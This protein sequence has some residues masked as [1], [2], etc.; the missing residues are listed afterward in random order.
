MTIS[1]VIEAWSSRTSSDESEDGQKFRFNVSTGY[2]V[3]HTYD[4]E[5][6]EIL[7]DYRVPQLGDTYKDTYAI[8]KRR[9]VSKVGQLLSIVAC[10]YS[11]ETG[12]DGP[13]D[14]P[15]NAAVEYNWTSAKSTE[16]IDVDV[17][18]YPIVTANGEEINGVT[19]DFCDSVL[20][21][22]KNFAVFTN[23]TKQAYLHSVNVDPIIIDDDLFLPGTGK[24]ITLDIKPMKLGDF[25]YKEVT[26]SIQFRYPY[27]T[28]PALAWASRVRHEGN[29]E[30]LGPVVSFSGGGG[31]GAEAVAFSNA[32]GALTGIFVT[33]FGS[34][35][36]SNPTVSVSIG[37]GATFTVTRGGYNGDEVRT[38][39]VTAGGTGYKVRVVR[40]CDSNGEPTVKPVLLSSTGFRTT[41]DSA[42][43]LSVQKYAPLPYS[44]LGIA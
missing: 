18:G 28:T 6:T 17:Y 4:T 43:W 5:E 42:T 10:E 13:T 16:S 25:K 3:I 35:Y 31:T 32:S 23:S 40:A 24:M 15:L 14:N 34:G 27:N 44:I 36:T 20:N 37:S 29:Y 39:A 8:L 1:N 21:F 11:G 41:A 2:Q 22:K 33:R 26:G 30:R 9:N 19:M 12:P 38:V 7:S